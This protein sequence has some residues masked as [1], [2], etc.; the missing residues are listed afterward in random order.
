MAGFVTGL[1]E[2]MPL[3]KF[4]VVVLIALPG[5]LYST[6]NRTLSM[7]SPVQWKPC[8]REVCPVAHR[9]G[10]KRD[11]ASVSDGVMVG[12]R[13]VLQLQFTGGSR[14]GAGMTLKLYE[15]KKRGPLKPEEF[16]EATSSNL[17]MLSMILTKNDLHT[18]SRL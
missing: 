2:S 10:L 4:P 18:L 7:S 14:I 1:L 5:S 11:L 9:N 13:P 12:C 15:F 6:L 8:L 16:Y 17:K 3:A